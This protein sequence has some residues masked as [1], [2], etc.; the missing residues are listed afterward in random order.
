MKCFIIAIALFVSFQGFSQTKSVS[1]LITLISK[2]DTVYF[3]ADNSGCFH[4]YVFEVK[5]CRQKS[6]E[7]KLIMKTDTGLVEKR[8]TAK[9]YQ[10]FIN[11]YKTS[12]NYFIKNNKQTCTS[13][14]EFDLYCKT[15]SGSING[16]KFKNMNC[17]AKYNPEMF[18]QDLLRVKE[19]AKK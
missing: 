5:L 19:V 10:A 6:G 9:K 3:V 14:T 8:L 13:T 4:A 16:S 1:S 2:A 18:L 12:T 11:N 17:D 7:R 15:K